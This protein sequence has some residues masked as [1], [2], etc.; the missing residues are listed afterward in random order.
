MGSHFYKI[1]NSVQPIY[2]WNMQ[3]E[4]LTWGQYLAIAVQRDLTMPALMLKRS[5][6]V[7]PG[8]LGTPA[9][10]ITTSAPSK[11]FP[12]CSSPAY[13]DTFFFIKFSLNVNVKPT[14][15]WPFV[16]QFTIKYYQSEEEKIYMCSESESEKINK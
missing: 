1:P 16:T 12:R 14:S 2:K 8:F 4:R 5:S 11:A 6:R 3:T 7:I 10:M 9:G 13:P 15:H